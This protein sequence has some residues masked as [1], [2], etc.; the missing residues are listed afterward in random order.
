VIVQAWWIEH[1]EAYV[2]R[3]AAAN[4]LV[5]RGRFNKAALMEACADFGWTEKE[6]RNKMY[7]WRG[8]KEIKD[9]GGWVALV[10]AGMGIY[11]FCKYRIGFDRDSMQ[12]L[13]SLRPALEV[14]ADTLQYVFQ[15]LSFLIPWIF[16][17]SFRDCL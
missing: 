11:R 15:L 2:D 7:V 17:G 13:R 1:F 16:S 14:A 6:L 9:A 3:W 8:Y 5:P 12:R 10:F 4:P